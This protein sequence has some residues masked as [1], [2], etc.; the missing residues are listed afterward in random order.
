ML[1]QLKADNNV[2]LGVYVTVLFAVVT[3]WHFPMKRALSNGPE[4]YL[5]GGHQYLIAGGGD[6]LYAFKL[7]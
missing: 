7:N 3:L 5:L 4:T 2:F 6:T 1:L